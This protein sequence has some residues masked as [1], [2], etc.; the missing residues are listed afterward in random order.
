MAIRDANTDIFGPHQYAA[1]AAHIQS[2][3]SGVI[4]TRI[5]DRAR[6]IKAI[7]ADAELSKVRDIVKNPSTLKNKSLAEINYNYHAALWKSL[8]VLEDNILI[9]HE[10][11]ASNGSYT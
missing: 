4:A 3:V 10:P 1:P 6:W 9:Y 5:P 8:I 2:L 7:D 11:L